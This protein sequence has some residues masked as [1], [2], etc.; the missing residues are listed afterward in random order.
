MLSTWKINSADYYVNLA[1][2]S[3]GDYLAGSGEAP[4]RW[5]GQGLAEFAAAARAAGI[6]VPDGVRVGETIDKDGSEL[7]KWIV[8]QESA[9]TLFPDQRKP[10]RTRKDRENADK[11]AAQGKAG[12]AAGEYCA[13]FDLTFSAPKG[14]SICAEMTDDAEL[15][16][17]LHGCLDRAVAT[18][19]AYGEQVACWG[20]EGTDGVDVVP[21][22]GFVAAAFRH[23]TSRPP[24]KG[25]IPD[26]QS[27][28]HVLVGN[29]VRHPDGTWGALDGRAIY[30][31]KMAAGAMFRTALIAEVEAEGFDFPWVVTNAARGL[32]EMDIP[33][34]LL[35]ATG[36]RRNQIKEAAERLGL[37]SQHGMDGA[38]LLTREAKMTDA[39]HAGEAVLPAM[40]RARPELDDLSDEAKATLAAVVAGDL[41]SRGDALQP[42]TDAELDSIAAELVSEAS[43][44]PKAEAGQSEPPPG[45][46]TATTSTFRHPQVVAALAWRAMGTGTSPEAIDAAA[47]RLLESSEAVQLGGPAWQRRWSTRE[48]LLLEDRIIRMAQGGVG[49]GAGAVSSG[50]AETIL[51]KNAWLSDE[52]AAMVRH[53]TTSGNAVDV[54]VGAAGSGKTAALKVANEAWLAAGTRVIGC[55]HASRAAQGLEDGSGIRSRTMAGLLME[56]RREDGGLPA[57][58][59]VVVDET[60]MTDTRPVAELATAVAASHGKL[61]LVGDHRQLQAV[62]AGGVYRALVGGESDD[63]DD[64]NEDNRI[65]VELLGN[66][67]QNEAWERSVLARLREDEDGSG[68]RKAVEAWTEH[69]RLHMHKDLPDAYVAC[70][71]GWLADTDAGKETTMIATRVEDATALAGLARAVL[72]ERGDIEDGIE[73]TPGGLKFATGDRVIC[74]KNNSR[75]G[76]RNGNAGTITGVD[77]SPRKHNVTLRVHLDHG[78]DVVLPT[79]YLDAGNVAYGHGTSNHKVQGA[80]LDT[81]HVLGTSLGSREAAYVAASRHRESV[82][83]HTVDPKAALRDSG[84]THGLEIVP[85][86]T[87]AF[88]DQISGRSEEWAASHYGPGKEGVAPVF[89]TGLGADEAR[90]LFQERLQLA[91]QMITEA[92]GEA[93]RVDPDTLARY[94]AATG[95]LRTHAR[96][97]G[98]EAV[99][100]RPAHVVKAL[101][102]PPLLPQAER[103]WIGAAGAIEAYRERWEITGDATLGTERVTDPAQAQDRKRVERIIEAAVGVPEPVVTDEDADTDDL[104]QAG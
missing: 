44:W 68:V 70:V 62:G 101:G 48:I 54:V 20:R 18:A 61:V 97:M 42:L 95:T 31:W 8:S 52:Q 81:A 1:A 55:A 60:S 15:R 98:Q 69:G 83:I 12:K 80:T 56:L 23:R 49:A 25:A 57:G 64:E 77:V 32:V 14:F 66:R 75:L 5:L 13:A 87:D 71:R 7:L 63:E 67:R 43:T 91:A 79:T 84:M 51:G 78:E 16:Q 99:I 10:A 82:T 4:G 40:L 74:L 50:V 90:E 53:V 27:H 3:Y 6:E 96:Q 17:R 65:V 36:R 35:E 9:D 26:P 21:G 104:A 45:H 28:I 58:C 19:V 100:T 33:D 102:D 73:A 103:R 86:A 93:R 89:V 2:G 85:D 37:T 76:V 11:Q 92:H 30:A 24:E 88:V 94:D 41:P 38:T 34:D 59:V 47:T 46:L 72:V 22:G 39:A 29:H